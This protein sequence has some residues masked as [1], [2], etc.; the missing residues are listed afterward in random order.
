MTPQGKTVSEGEIV[1]K[2]DP[3]ALRQL[4]VLR[5]QAGFLTGQIQAASSRREDLVLQM[6]HAAPER[7]AIMSQ[8]LRAL[9]TQLAELETSAA[10]LNAQMAQTVA[11]VTGQPLKTTKVIGSLA[12][13]PPTPPMPTWS[14]FGLGASEVFLLML[15]PIVALSAWRFLRRGAS[16]MISRGEWNETSQRLQRIEIAVDT[17]ALE[18]ERVSEA[19]RF[20]ART[21][22]E[23]LKTLKPIAGVRDLV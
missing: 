5:E 10:R 12:P 8:Q 21:I 22:G 17:I 1:F 3:G 9:D 13:P 4:E 23:D 14:G 19:Q 7:V 18:V 15:L 2:Q 11:V 16:Q 6:R 20:L